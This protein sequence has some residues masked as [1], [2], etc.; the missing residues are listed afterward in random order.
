M[1]EEGWSDERARQLAS[2][3]PCKRSSESQIVDGGGPVR[4]PWPAIATTPG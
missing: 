1:Y 4:M 2:A 3:R